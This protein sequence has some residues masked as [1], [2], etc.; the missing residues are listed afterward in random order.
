MGGS[1]CT[2]PLGGDRIPLPVPGTQRTPRAGGGDTGG[3]EHPRSCH[4][5]GRWCPGSSIWARH[6]QGWWLNKSIFLCFF[7]LFFPELSG[8]KQHGKK[9]RKPA[10][11]CVSHQP[12][13]ALPWAEHSQ[14]MAGDGSDSTMPHGWTSKTTHEVAVDT[15]SGKVVFGWLDPSLWE[16]EAWCLGEQKPWGCFFDLMHNIQPSVFFLWAVFSQ[17]GAVR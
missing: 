7:F 9:R 3:A 15:F 5:E 17:P 16:R 4:P 8:K 13:L 12:R 10:A 11:L 6:H 1:A 2:Q 14:G